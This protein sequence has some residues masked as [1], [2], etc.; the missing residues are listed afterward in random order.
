M[1]LAVFRNVRRIRIFSGFGLV[2]KGMRSEFGVLGLILWK[3]G[4]SFKICVI[5]VSVLLQNL[6]WFDGG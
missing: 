6:H 1:M 2:K 5:D 4:H 3:D